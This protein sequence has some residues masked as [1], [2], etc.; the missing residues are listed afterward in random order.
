MDTGQKHNAILKKPHKF[1]FLTLSKA[2]LCMLKCNYTF[3][4]DLSLPS[5]LPLTKEVQPNPAYPTDH[6]EHETESEYIRLYTTLPA[7]SDT[8][9]CGRLDP[10]SGIKSEMLAC[11]VLGLMGKSLKAKAGEGRG[12]EGGLGC[13]CRGSQVLGLRELRPVE[14]VHGLSAGHVL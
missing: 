12:G 11:C 6:Y 10:P 13:S 7:S 8:V 4:V 14:H 9:S 2:F 3:L 1:N 5:E